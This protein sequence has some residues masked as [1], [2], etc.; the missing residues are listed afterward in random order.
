MNIIV[1]TSTVIAVIAGEPEKATILSATVGH[2]LFAPQ[3]LPWEVGNAFSAMLKRR[4]TTLTEVEASLLLYSRMDITLT[5]V[6]LT[7]A[8]SNAA[9]FGIY[10]YDAYVL[11]CAIHLRCPLITLDNGLIH[12]AKAAGVSLIEVK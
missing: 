12:V 5:E 9:R 2:Q 7:Q 3:S 11:T 8:L 1:D 4:R 10:A 6:D